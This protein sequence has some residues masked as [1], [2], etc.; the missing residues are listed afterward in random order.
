MVTWH[1]FPPGKPLLPKDTRLAGLVVAAED[2][3]LTSKEV[4]TSTTL[5]KT[6]YFVKVTKDAAITLPRAVEHKDRSYTIMN[7]G[8]KVHLDAHDGDKIN[9]ITRVTLD[10]KYGFVTVHSEGADK[11]WLII[12][13]ANVALE[14][15]MIDL[16]NLSEKQWGKMLFLMGKLVR[17]REDSSTLD[18]GDD[19]EEIEKELRKLDV[20]TNA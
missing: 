5:G 10:T 15:T 6:H 13:G 14:N 8:G 16:Y 4:A 2:I 19:K 17:Y 3:R 12:G 20:R 1:D 11:Q 7:V 9:D 18:L